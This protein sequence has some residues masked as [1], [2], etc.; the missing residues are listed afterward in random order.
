[1]KL[2]SRFRSHL[3]CNTQGCQSIQGTVRTQG[4]IAAAKDQLLGLDVELNLANAASAQLEIGPLGGQP[5]IDLVDVDLP[6]DR[7]DVSNG[8]KIEVLAPDKARQLLKKALAQRHVPG[9]GAGL[10]KGCPLPVLADGLVIVEGCS[11]G[12]GG[13][14]RARIGTQA[15]IDPKDI[16]LCRA[17]LQ[18][19]RQGPCH[20]QRNG[21][22]I[23]A[24]R[25]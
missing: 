5:I 21:L 19:L 22:R 9:H 3:T 1:M 4:R 23:A 6:L 7:M 11:H 13:R 20:G 24:F 2:C 14:G 12:H 18:Q 15:Q 8:G 10:D 25:D 16:A 17:L